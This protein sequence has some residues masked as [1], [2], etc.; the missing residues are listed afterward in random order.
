MTESAGCRDSARPRLSGGQQK[1]AMLVVRRQ[2]HLSR[3]NGSAEFR[4]LT[5]VYCVDVVVV[6]VVLLTRTIVYCVDVVVVVV[7]VQVVLLT[8]TTVYCVDVVVVQAVLL[9]RTTVYCVDVVVVVV[10][11]TVLLTRTTAIHPQSLML[12]MTQMTGTLYSSSHLF[13]SVI[14]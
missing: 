13:P 6:Q 8:R 9:T 5:T 12:S 14:R 4:A 2:I 7:V 10:V 3:A 11:Q 1:L